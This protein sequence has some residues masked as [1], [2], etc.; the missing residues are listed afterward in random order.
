M[1]RPLALLATLTASATLALAPPPV[2]GQATPAEPDLRA[3]VTEISIGGRVQTQLNTSSV[4]G[5]APS[6]LL[7][8]RARMELEVT[9]NDRVGGAIQADFAGNQVDIKDAYLQLAL[10]PSISVL[11][12]KAH[13]PFSL[14]DLTSSKR[15]P[16]IEP[17]L[18]IRGVVAG[19]ELALL[20][21][22]DYSDRDI[23]IQVLGDPA[24]A[25]FDLTYAA[26]VFRGPLH[27]AVGDQD[28][29]QYA[30]RVTGR[31]SPEIRI[32]AA[33]SSRDFAGPGAVPELRRGHAFEVDVEYGAFAPGLHVLA[34]VAGGDIDPFTDATFR[35]I[36]TWVAYRTG[37]LGA[38]VS[39]LEPVFRVSY[40]DTDDD[41][42]ALTPPGGTL[43]TPGINIYFTPLNRLML[44]YDVW[45]GGDDSPDATSF[46]V[47][48]QLGF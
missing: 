47:M 6:Q 42:V 36:N 38:L 4:D 27:G 20:D 33:W 29:Y 5:V 31:A 35:G 22:L 10:T 23:G 24:D 39:A 28:S 18:R 2:A 40:T 19:E 7:I 14:M 46:K 1:T 9:I 43:L 48:F 41:G 13:R 45:R 12:G 11:A 34:E 16:F 30:A 21:G 25:P 3:N 15:M 44:D 37:P 26:G 17:G 8:R 32:G